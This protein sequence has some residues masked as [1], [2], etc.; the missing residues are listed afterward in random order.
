VTARLAETL[1]AVT[2]LLLLVLALRGLVA[3][4]FGAGWAY[5]LWLVPAL[6]LVLP[7][8]PILVPKIAL[9]PAAFIPA[10]AGAA[11]PL[12]AYAGLGQWVPFLLTIWAGG[13]AAFLIL[14]GLAY[15]AFLHRLHRTS[16][17]GEPPLYGGIATWIS[18]IVQGPLA[19]G[20]FERRIV[21]PED[22]AS[23]Y[24][25]G[26]QRLALEHELTHHRRGDLI[27]NLL[28]LLFLAVNWFN[29]VAW[30]AFRAFRSDQE[31]AC[32]AAVAARAS[33][34]ERQDY[35]RALVKSATTPGLIAVCPL[36]RADQLK[37]RLGMI[38]LHRTS[39]ARRGGGVALLTLFAIAALSVGLGEQ[40]AAP[41]QAVLATAPQMPVQA[42]AALQPRLAGRPKAKPAH[43]TRRSP[44]AVRRHKTRQP[45]LAIAMPPEAPQ[46]EMR[47][48]AHF[49]SRTFTHD[50]VTERHTRILVLG[51]E[52]SPEQRA[53]VGAEI[54]LALARAELPEAGLGVAE[55]D[56][57]LV[58]G[59]ASR[60]FIRRI[61]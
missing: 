49:E 19:L 21:L 15:R 33:A 14:H 26:E 37:R 16:R 48:V 28:A 43:Q 11:A 38:G 2:L 25:A 60:I 30:L 8:L 39:P 58:R 5:A 1:I 46:P 50:G 36:H 12:P 29:P 42:T 17:P 40:S 4:R 51:G 57:R 54:R 10:A 22:F 52:L 18:G 24:S 53:Q 44:P 13:A 56:G 32:D 27:W 31:L 7:P 47:Q 34:S 41:A 20:I 9:S 55:R 61:N 23:R 6:R 45:E 59:E 35:A 3:R